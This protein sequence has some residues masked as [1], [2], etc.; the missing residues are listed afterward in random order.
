M[1]TFKYYVNVIYRKMI[2]VVLSLQYTFEYSK[3][4]LIGKQRNK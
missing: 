3:I 4:K 1:T 2:Y